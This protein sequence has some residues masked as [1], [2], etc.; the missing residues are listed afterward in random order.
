MG[1]GGDYI[2]EETAPRGYR[3]KQQ[4]DKAVAV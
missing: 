4:G 2:M 3:E 1:L